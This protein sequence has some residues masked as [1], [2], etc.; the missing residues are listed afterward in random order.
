MPFSQA[1]GGYAARGWPVFPVHSIADG[2]CT[3][4]KADC[5][6]PA[7]HPLT[8]HGFKDATTDPATIAEWAARWPFANV[9]LV[10]GG[11]FVV[12]DIDPRNRGT[13]SLDALTATHGA[14]P[15]TVETITG[16]GGRHIFFSS[17]ADP[18]RS[19]QL[20]P[21]VDFKAAGGYVVAPPSLHASG[22]RYEWEGSSE[23]DAVPL[24]PLPDWIAT[25]ANGTR[26]P[27]DLGGDAISEGSRNE[28]LTRI[29]GG[30]RRRGLEVDVIASQLDEINRAQCRPPLDPEEVR[31]IAESIGRYAPAPL[32][33]RFTEGG[34]GDGFA[35]REFPFLR[36]CAEW[37][38]W[39]WWTGT[40]WQT[41]KTGEAAR[42]AKDLV[43]SLYSK[44]GDVDEDGERRRLVGWAR[45]LDTPRA[46]A[47]ILDWS[48]TDARIAREAA[49]FDQ[50]VY[51][52]NCPNGTLNLRTF[53][54]KRHDQGDLIT[55][56]CPTPYDPDAAAPLWDQHLRHFLP[57]PEVRRQI[58]RDLGLALTGENLDEVLSVWYGRGA[59]AKST[60]LEVVRRV[61]GADYS[62]EAVP[63]LLIQKKHE[64]HL[65]ELAALR[66]KRL[67]TSSEIAAGAILDESR[68]KSLTGGG[69]QVARGMRE[70]PYSFARTW[71]II[72]DC[73]SRPQIRA[74]DDAIWRRV[75]VVPWQVSALGWEGRRPQ[76]HVIADL[77]AEAPGILAWIV[78][79]L[80]DWHEEPRWI[81]ERVTAATADY[82]ATQD[83]LGDWMRDCCKADPLG[84]AP[85]NALWQSYNEWCEE[86]KQRPLGRKTF[87][88]RLSEQG[89]EASTGAKKIRIREGLRLLTFTERAKLQQQDESAS[90]VAFV[91]D[92][93]V[94]RLVSPHGKQTGTNATNA[95]QHTANADEKALDGAL[96]SENTERTEG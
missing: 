43:L 83:A 77:M 81:A 35:D 94:E 67:V 36:F 79:G 3:C 54:L 6:S 70:N 34:A 37:R 92:L 22:R 62:T 89:F 85:F 64:G 27:P 10:T 49:A 19:G 80:Q 4:G 96:F 38:R 71:T 28:T 25:L 60:T 55:S 32:P 41:D 45:K 63:N 59:N 21:G 93:P 87:G 15:E 17:P 58:Q 24:A 40:H 84:S 14:L 88:E 1:A 51:L 26:R 12:L 47:A 53:E 31:G 7:K 9:A 72:L 46:T 66:A 52:L 20:A 78:E 29:A 18:L 5:G 23:P 75:R 69:Q 44:A 61:L 42:R 65:A 11:A 13:E 39:L 86:T 76:E 56:L 30:L 33:E 16:G 68:V 95:T 73:N 82:R 2:V 74:S 91:A 50:A 48:S 90:G 8:P 57:D